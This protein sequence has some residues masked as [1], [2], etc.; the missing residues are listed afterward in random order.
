MTNFTKEEVHFALA[1]GPSD[2]PVFVAMHEH[3]GQPELTERP[4]MAKTYDSVG[5][6][7]AALSSSKKAPITKGG[8]WRVVRLQ[9]RISVLEL[10]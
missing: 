2:G 1:A 4:H 8:N 10:G 6:A 9:V 7:S 5:A 3:Q